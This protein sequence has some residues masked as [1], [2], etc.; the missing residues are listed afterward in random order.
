[1]RGKGPDDR[2]IKSNH[3]ICPDRVPRQPQKVHG[4]AEPSDDHSNSSS[5]NV[6][7]KD[8]EAGEHHNDT[9]DQIR[10]VEVPPRTCSTLGRVA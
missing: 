4:C 9:E 3:D 1:M 2:N 8:A 6:P 10:E 7:R 5:G